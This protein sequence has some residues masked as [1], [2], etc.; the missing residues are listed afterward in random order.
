MVDPS[1]DE[2]ASDGQTYKLEPRSMRLL[3]ALAQS[4]GSVVSAE[5]LLQTVWPG[6]LV[7][8]S[9]LYDAIAQLRKVLGPQHIGTVARKGYRL[10][11]PIEQEAVLPSMEASGAEG[12]GFGVA[13]S[14]VQGLGPRSIA[15]L[16]FRAYGLPDSLSF[17]R[18]RLVDGLISAM[19]RQ[20]GL[21]MVASGTMLTFQENQASPQEVSRLLGARFVISGMLEART[22][23]LFVSMQVADGWSGTQTFADE[24]ELPLDAWHEAAAQVV[25]RLARALNFELNDLVARAAFQPGDSLMQALALSARAWVALFARVQTRESNAQASLLAAQ[26]LALAPDL[27]Q[28]WMCKGYCEWRAG[29]YGWSDEPYTV[30]MDHALAS[31]QRAVALDPRDPDAQYVLGVVSVH[32]GQLLQ[33]EEALHQCL[34]LTSSYAPAHAILGLVRIRRGYPAEAG[35]HCDRA[36]ALSPREP[37]RAIWH[38]IKAVAALVLGDSHTALEE[39]QRGIAAN[40]SYPPCYVTG[41]AAAQSLGDERQ[42]RAWVEVLRERTVFN[43]LAAFRLRS[44][45]SY[46]SQP[47]QLDLLLNLLRDAGMPER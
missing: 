22:D 42:A 37:L 18:E 12:A 30:M 46:A 11:T 7:T 27:A 1:S 24:L 40:A 45:R 21:V 33:A 6:L 31:V 16:P 17:L 44:Q 23:R 14:G 5:A 34:R 39:C 25:P 43:S 8:Q 26:A 47:G 41:A 15:V 35:A 20:P 29:Q 32:H 38:W 19:S 13:L 4:G 28:A 9:S 3:C 10:L 2:V 36:F